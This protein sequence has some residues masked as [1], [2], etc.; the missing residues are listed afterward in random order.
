MFSML[1]LLLGVVNIFILLKELRERGWSLFTYSLIYLVVFFN[2]L[3]V[4][5][6]LFIESDD[7]FAYKI[8]DFY[9]NLEVVFL[10]FTCIILGF[11]AF[12][13]GY[14]FTKNK[15]LQKE[16]FL[17]L[18]TN[19][20]IHRKDLIIIIISFFSVIGLIM[21][22]R[23]FGSIENAIANANFVRS[24]Y[25]SSSDDFGDTSHTFFFRFIFISI[26]PLIYYFTLRQKI[27]F[28]KIIFILSIVILIILYFFLSPGRQSIIDIILIFILNTLVSKRKILNWQLIV[29]GILAV[30]S[31][32]FLEI[33][34]NTN[35]LNLNQVDFD[36]K[37][38]LVNEFGFPFY[39][40]YYSIDRD[41]DFFFFSD[42]ITGMYG[43]IFPSSFNPGIEKTNYLN[44]FFMTNQ[45][46]RGYVPPGLFA[47]GYYSFGIIGVV[48]IS[49]FTG[50]F[51][52]KID[53]Y[54]R[55]LLQIEPKYTIF[56]T[57]FIVNSMVWI[58]TGLPENYFYNFT[59][60]V[61]WIFI[62]LSFKIQNSR[63]K[64]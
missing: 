42:F 50:W 7:N 63:N 28:H 3:P 21:Y 54:F 33:L 64:I 59:F 14:Y 13:C 60:M 43:K 9:H 41:Y 12:Y 51:F 15:T 36:L 19:G 49:G 61:F 24:G 40:L 30:I 5:S 58:R 2:V 52:K 18:K 10:L 6:L 17:I 48:L 53:L 37:K 47:Q 34:L 57:Y 32:P 22:I 1:F 20:R 4:I 16:S 26:I 27:L 25:Y 45:Q 39:S 31:L 56:Y 38:T 8:P 44:T 46:G 29:T 62:F 11:S 23:G 35:Q 55:K